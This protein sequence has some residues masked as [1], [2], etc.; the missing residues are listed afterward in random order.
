MRKLSRGKYLIQ[1]KKA[2]VKELGRSSEGKA[3][4]PTY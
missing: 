3:T 2:G 1:T 4:Y